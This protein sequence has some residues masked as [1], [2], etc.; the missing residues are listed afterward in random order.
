MLSESGARATSFDR[1]AEQ[2]D[3][4]R[5]SYPDALVDDVL[6]RTGARRL[7]EIGAGTGQATV[8]FARRGCTITAL[9]PGARLAAVLRRNVAG[10]AVTVEETRFE[11]HGGSGYDL[12][13]AAQ[14]FHWVEAGARYA[15][16]VASWLA[17]ITNEKEP[18][19]SGLRAEFDVAYARWMPGDDHKHDPIEWT[20]KRWVGELDASGHYGPVHVGQFPWRATYATRA[21][22]DL[23]DTYSDHIS[24]PDDRR[25]PLYAAIADAIERR[26]G[27]IEIPYLA[28]VFLARRP[29]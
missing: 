16:D 15:R 6:A 8:P 14:A 5:P 19:D 28:M 12:A 24:L 1:K 26:G 29:R 7:L 21:Y 2:Y 9:E 23:I 22:L 27:Q 20:R 17:I 11:D 25:V 10:H 4:A 18:I 3:A 13:Y